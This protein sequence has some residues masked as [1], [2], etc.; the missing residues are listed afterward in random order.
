VPADAYEKFIM[1]SNVV[2][3][4]SAEADELDS[5]ASSE[6]LVTFA[7]SGKTVPW[8]A[9][10]NSLLEFAEEHGVDMSFGCRYGDCGT[11]MTHLI[12]GSVQ[13]LHPTGASPDPGTCLPCSCKPET[14]IELDA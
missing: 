7:R 1:K 8:T 9:D 5:R 6:F 13:Y 10:A 12:R 3:G 11:C 14:D 2:E 4:N